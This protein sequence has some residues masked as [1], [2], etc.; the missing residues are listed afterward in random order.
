MRISKYCAPNLASL[1][2]FAYVY[3][4]ICGHFHMHDVYV[5]GMQIHVCQSTP[6]H[7]SSSNCNAAKSGLQL[8]AFAFRTGII[9]GAPAINIPTPHMA[10]RC[11]VQVTSVQQVC[12]VKCSIRQ[13]RPDK[14]AFKDNLTC[15]PRLEGA[16][17]ICSMIL[18]Y[19]IRELCPNSGISTSK[20]YLGNI[21]FS[22][23]F[24]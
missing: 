20:F 17:K 22:S 18:K 24:L 9:V 7:L 6:Y 11:S 19:S 12:C 5:Q 23:S 16:L 21:F 14:D 1:C 2:I 3:I 15:V 13:S 4:Y 8:C 10:S